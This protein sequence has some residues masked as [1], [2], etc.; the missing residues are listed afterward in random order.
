MVISNGRTLA[1]S[2]GR[3]NR[4]AASQH[5]GARRRAAVLAVAS[6]LSAVSIAAPASA[7]PVSQPSFDPKQT[8]K[9]F[10]DVQS[11]SSPSS[12]SQ[13][14]LPH[15]ARPASAADGKPLFVLRG[16]SIAGAA[17]IAPAELATVYQPYLG[18]KVSQADLAA[19]ATAISDCYRAAGF[20]LTRAIIPP[21]DIDKGIVRVQVFEGSI[22]DVVLKGD[23]AEEFSVRPLLA[24]VT[25]EHPSRLATLERQLL[26]ING[27]PGVRIV[28]S[29]IEELGEG[30][31][32]FRLV[33]SLKTWHI[34]ASFGADNLGAWSVGPWQGYA[35]AAFNSYL[36]PGDTLAVNLSTT[37]ADLRELGFARLAYDTPV[38]TDGARIGASAFYSQV[39][40]G[41][42]RRLFSDTTITD[43]F[44]VHGSVVPIQSLRSS[45]MFTLAAGFME[46]SE[47]IVFGP[48]YKDHIRTI[49]MTADYRWLDDVAGNNYFT[50]TYR[51][52]LDLF[53]AS[54]FGDGLT[55]RFG[56]SPDFTVFNF[57]YTR[58]QP[59]PGAWSIKLA[60]AN[61]TALGPLYASQQFY[62]GGLAFG[63]GYGSAEVSGDNG[64]AGSV[65]L[66][67]DTKLNF[68]YLSGFQLYSFVDSGV[69]WN[70]GFRPSDGVTLTS[71]GAGVRL[72]LW[73]DLLADLGVAFP[74]SY[75][76]PDNEMR[77][78]RVL[79]SLSSAL[80][81]CPQRGSAGC[82]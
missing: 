15:L 60:A 43:A 62:L 20:H 42:I 39:R 17:A 1:G 40:P 57:Y 8:E 27:V 21:Q 6:L 7:E 19:I 14:A 5:R 49:S 36:Q 46:A 81:M 44:E 30:T 18:K 3:R 47:S 45:L 50:A 33:L 29:S 13:L 56:A 41:D 73:N 63:R 54:Q 25:A 77:T 75:R 72:F 59:L 4:R 66:R 82:L 61:Q 2:R 11:Q 12:R 23:G 76:S 28:D 37:P 31:G 52:G 58:Y 32:R 78:A 80:K 79:V 70:D 48:I 68:Q 24:A 35:T 38:G 67:Y 69:V 26:L 9:Y 34:Y 71:A 65:E 74:L 22:T 53:G 64:L 16:V 55:S 51:Q 10:D